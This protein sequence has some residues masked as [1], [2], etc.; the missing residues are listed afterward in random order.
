MSCSI[1]P[2]MINTL[3]QLQRYEEQAKFKYAEDYKN[4]N[5]KLMGKLSYPQN[6]L[7]RSI[8]ILIFRQKK[9][10]SRQSPKPR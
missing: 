9:Y 1:N 7:I 6:H 10:T 3:I 2:N 8:L 4:I 5:L